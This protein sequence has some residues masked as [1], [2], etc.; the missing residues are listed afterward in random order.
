M[1]DGVLACIK[2][3]LDHLIGLCIT[4]N[5]LHL[6]KNSFFALH[7]KH[8]TILFEIDPILFVFLLCLWTVRCIILMGDCC[9]G[10]P[11]NFLKLA[12]A[13]GSQTPRQ[14]FGSMSSNSNFPIST[15]STHHR[16]ID[17]QSHELINWITARK[18]ATDQAPVE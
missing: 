14:T 5:M 2:R 17:R 6:F 11:F 18:S 10:M 7:I 1:K 3:N 13:S 4:L 8:L 15:S 9:A 16:D 12:D